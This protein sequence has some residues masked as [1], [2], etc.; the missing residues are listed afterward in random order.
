MSIPQNIAR[1]RHHNEKETVE[2]CNN[3]RKF[4]NVGLLSIIYML[5]AVSNPSGFLSV[6]LAYSRRATSATA[7]AVFAVKSGQQL[8]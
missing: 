5:N 8:R 3:C 6:I 1:H 7:C 2:I 4:V